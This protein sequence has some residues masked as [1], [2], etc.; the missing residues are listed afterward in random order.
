MH[1]LTA[2][3]TDVAYRS[4]GDGRGLV[5]LHGSFSDGASAF[6]H[7]A[8]RWADR[9]TVITPDYAG[10]GA[11]TVPDG[12]LS[13]D[14]LVD[15]A[16]AVIKD[17]ADEPVDLLG[18]SLGAVVAA[19]TAARHPGLV[20]RLVLVAG[21]QSSDDPRHQL[22]FSTWHRLFGTDP[23][24]ALRYGLSLAFSPEFLSGLGHDR[25]NGLADRS[26]PP[27]T[28]RRIELGLRIDLRAETPAIA[29]P[30]LVVGLTQDQLVPPRHA[31]ELRAAIPA[32]TYAEL[33]SGHAVQLERPDELVRITRDFLFQE[34]PARQAGTDR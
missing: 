26:F 14:T 28:D 27:A 1:A 4:A 3:G 10:A 12:P 31:R 32:S 16:A 30:T 24:L 2:S 5:L 8:D 9:R 18:T 6:G 13:L 19:A 11:S 34:E 29:A 33:D 15:Q 17:A 21:W 7:I 23:A 22:V 20:R 25:L